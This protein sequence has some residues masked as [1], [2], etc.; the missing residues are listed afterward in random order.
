M[1]ARHDRDPRDSMAGDRGLLRRLGSAAGI[2]ALIGISL[3][4]TMSA[5][6]ADALKVPLS[7][8]S[9][10]CIYA[11]G[12]DEGRSR[13]HSGKV[14]AIGEFL[15]IPACLR[16]YKIGCMQLD[17]IVLQPVPCCVTSFIRP[18]LHR[19]EKNILRRT[20]T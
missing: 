16:G 20:R 14:K 4:F 3:L 11:L 8:I 7:S 10:F 17:Y 12:R 19:T 13:A 2:A 15:C 9:A 1:D 5:G 6:P 18:Y